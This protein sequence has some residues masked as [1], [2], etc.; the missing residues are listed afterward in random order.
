MK[1]KLDFVTNSSSSSFVVLGTS[2]NFDKI[3]EINKEKLEDDIEELSTYEKL[4][5]INDNLLKDS[6][7]Q[8]SFGEYGYYDRDEFIIGMHYTQM[9]DDETLTQFKQRIKDQIKSCLGIEVTTVSHIQE[10]WM[11]T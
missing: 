5:S 3:I 9:N 6:K 11:D 1:I 2:C 8:T 4:E 7:L 10:C